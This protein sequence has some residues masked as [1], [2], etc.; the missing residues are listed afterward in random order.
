[1]ADAGRVEAFAAAD[2]AEFYLRR[3][4]PPGPPRGRLVVLPGVRSHGGW[5]GRSA[6]AFAA[7]G[8]TVTVLD[9]RGAGLNT[10]RRGDAPGFRRL[11]DDVAE[12]VLAERR[13][14]ADLPTVVMGISWGGKLA[15]GLP[16]RR[17]GLVDG[18]ILACPGFCPRVR[19]PLP[20]RL[21]IAAARLMNPTAPFPVPLNDPELFTASPDWQA[22]VRA[23]RHDLHAATAR[24][25]TASAAL[26]VYLRRARS[27]VRCPVLTL[28]AGRDRVIDNARTR[29]FVAGFASR[30]NRI[31]D[32]PAAEHTLEFEPPAQCDFVAD[33]MRWLGRRAV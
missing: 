13:T 23:N 12:F 18:L 28:L 33:V 19:P 3:Y 5:Y 2:G 21:R 7:A 24:F 10:S 27:A 11:L 25:L 6:A 15:A 30:D 14:R 4:R 20:T 31:Y 32:Y 26:D 17:P 8:L 22:F 29:R 1:M 9:R 16:Y